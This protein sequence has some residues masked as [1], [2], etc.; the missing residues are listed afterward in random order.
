MNRNQMTA[1]YFV[2]FFSFGF[3]TERFCHAKLKM[4]AKRKRLMAAACI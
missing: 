2:Y 4:T 3:C 1:F